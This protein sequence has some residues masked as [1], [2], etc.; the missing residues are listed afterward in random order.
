MHKKQTQSDRFLGTSMFTT[1]L[2]ISM[3][4]TKTGSRC[5]N[6]G[7]KVYAFG[8]SNPTI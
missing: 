8:F 5:W 1:L 4:I 2:V 6:W 3:R 7:S